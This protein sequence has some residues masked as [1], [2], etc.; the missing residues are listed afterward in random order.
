[1]GNVITREEEEVEEVEE[2][3]A[4]AELEEW[5]EVAGTDP[6][7]DAG[8][9]LETPPVLAK[10]A[11]GGAATPVTLELT[12]P[13]VAGV[14]GWEE[15]GALETTVPSVAIAA[16]AG[17]PPLVDPDP[18][19]GAPVPPIGAV[20]PGTGTGKGAGRGGAGADEATKGTRGSADG[21][22]RGFGFV[23]S[24]PLAAP[25]G[26]GAAASADEATLGI[27]AVD[28]EAGADG[29]D[30]SDNKSDEV[31]LDMDVT[32][33]DAVAVVAGGDGSVAVLDEVLATGAKTM[34]WPGPRV[35]PV[36]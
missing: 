10:A 13:P 30:G 29:V 27:E 19:S 23:A 25:A 1:V 33:G 6:D 7:N 26:G 9:I 15:G 3:D 2:E 17:A 18:A 21:R 8:E 31:G 34:S 28:V 36:S 32:A 20:G 12:S 4:G 11:L 35:A 24:S 14:G 16:L 5:E 22:E